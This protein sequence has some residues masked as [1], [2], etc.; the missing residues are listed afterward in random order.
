MIKQIKEFNEKVQ[1]IAV[2]SLVNAQIVHE[3]VRLGVPV[4]KKPLK[5]Q[6]LEN[7]FAILQRQE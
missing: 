3:V 2:T 7:A 6:S 5:K 1:F 4:V